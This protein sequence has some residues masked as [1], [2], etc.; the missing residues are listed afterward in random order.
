[1]KKRW[2]LSRGQRTVRNLI[3]GALLLTLIWGL[4]GWRLP[5]GELEIRRLE[6]EY[7]MGGTEVIC[8]NR[9]YDKSYVTCLAEGE[10]WITVGRATKVSGILPF[11]RMIPTLN[12]VLPK[13]GIV[14]VALPAPNED[15]GMT[16]AV[17]GTPP[18]A[19]SGTLELDL[20]GVDGGVWSC[21]WKETFSAQ[22]ERREDGWM[23]FQLAG[24]PEGHGERVYCAMSCLWDWDARIHYGYV[25]E[26]PYRLTLTDGQGAEVAFR[27]GTL[28]P[29]QCLTE[30][31]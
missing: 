2:R 4:A 8:I 23:L 3:L 26:H 10:D 18:E 24:H 9:A 11:S 31:R 7:L 29:N 13:K 5:T 30:T 25:G 28:P 21:P 14:V 20:I 15:G 1:M 12:H 27:S 22:G 19:V 6:R 17:W 16:V